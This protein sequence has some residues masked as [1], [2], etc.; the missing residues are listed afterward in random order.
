[1]TQPLPVITNVYRVAMV[2]TGPGG[3]RATNVIHIRKASSNASAVATAVD[4]NVTANMWQQVVNSASVTR[5]DVTPLDG[6]GATASLAVSGAKWTG[7]AGAVDAI[8]AFA[9]VVTLR[10]SLRGRSYRGRVYIPFIGESAQANGS[11]TGTA[12]A[13]TAWTNFIVAMAA[14]AQSVVVA[15]YLHATAQ[16]VT[17]AIIQ[18]IG[19]TQRRRQSRLRV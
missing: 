8:P 17:S 12:A 2:W 18:T 14:A 9:E 5:L 16:D 19:G 7:T 11:M 1:V 6:S 15:S 3:Q 13:Q 4:A 10:T